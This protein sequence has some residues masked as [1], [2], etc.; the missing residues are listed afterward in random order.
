MA[1]SGWRGPRLVLTLY[2]VLVTFAAVAGV[3]FSVVVDDPVPPRL[4]FVLTLPPTRLGFA[5]YGGVTIAAVLGVPLLLV[6]LA[7]RRDEYAVEADPS[8]GKD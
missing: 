4:F 1:R 7:S 3:L 5:V 2:A 8:N 6:V